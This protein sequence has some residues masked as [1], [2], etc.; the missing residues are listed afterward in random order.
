MSCSPQLSLV[1][2]CDVT[3]TCL[4][5]RVFCGNIVH[6]QMLRRILMQV[7]KHAFRFI[8]VHAQVVLSK[9][10]QVCLTVVCHVFLIS[11]GLDRSICFTFRLLSVHFA[12]FSQEAAAT[13]DV[14]IVDVSFFM[15]L[16]ICSQQ[17][18][19]F[20]VFFSFVFGS[21]TS[22]KTRGVPL[23]RGDRGEL[24]E[25]G[26]YHSVRVHC[27]HAVVFPVRLFLT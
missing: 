13:S 26:E 2:A 22:W 3:D 27:S 23:V 6:L 20:E 8:D 7:F 15:Q 18:V 24:E 9:Q 4:L 12:L 14:V 17:F 11:S 10:R 19:L 1:P 25:F 21:R 5:D 16:V